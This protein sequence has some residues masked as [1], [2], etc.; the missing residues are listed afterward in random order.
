MLF[1][2]ES[3]IKLLTEIPIIIHIIIITI[4]ITIVIIFIIII[5]IVIIKHVQTDSFNSRWPLRVL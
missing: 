4:I 2:D 5:I 3:I 1:I